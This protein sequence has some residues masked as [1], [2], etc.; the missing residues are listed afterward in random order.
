MSPTKLLINRLNSFLQKYERENVIFV[1]DTSAWLRLYWAVP[2][3]VPRF[4]FNYCN[5]GYPIRIT[6]QIKKEFY[7]NIVYLPQKIN[8]L[9]SASARYLAKG[10]KAEILAMDDIP[11]EKRGQV[12]QKI[13]SIFGEKKTN[14]LVKKVF[15]EA[16]QKESVGLDDN[17]I[18][19]AISE[20]NL[21][22]QEKRPFPGQGDCSKDTNPFGDYLIFKELEKLASKDKASI[23]FVTFDFKEKN[24]WSLFQEKFLADCGR[25]LLYVDVPSFDCFTSR[26][27]TVGDSIG[28]PIRNGIVS[29]HLKEVQELCVKET[30]PAVEDYFSLGFCYLKS[31]ASEKLITSVRLIDH[32]ESN[33]VVDFGCDNLGSASYDCEFDVIADVEVSYQAFTLNSH[34]PP[35]IAVESKHLNGK[36]LGVITRNYG[37][38]EDIL[39]FSKEHWLDVSTISFSQT[40]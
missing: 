29:K 39:D 31:P 5:C 24:Y 33:F 32:Q 18:R 16:N 1:L 25:E 11:I 36:A 21:L 30:G 8:Q 38:S 2:T 20:A 7:R 12:Y 40:D 26:F 15:A 3:R 4:L 14:D 34:E 17:E 19:D 13:F 28:I 35:A 23:V 37:N 27:G 22:F 9:T 10:E 6:E